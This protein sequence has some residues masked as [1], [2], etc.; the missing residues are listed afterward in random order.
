VSATSSNCGTEIEGKVVSPLRFQIQQNMTLYQ[1]HETRHKR[2]V[3]GYVIKEPTSIVTVTTTAI[4]VIT[5][6]AVDTVITVI[7]SL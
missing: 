5:V 4:T 2:E 6:T 3:S 7:L 1:R